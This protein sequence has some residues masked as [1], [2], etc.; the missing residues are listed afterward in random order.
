VWPR[1][2][3]QAVARLAGTGVRVATVVNFPA[4]GTD[5]AATVT[6][7]TQALADGADEIDLVLPY[8]AF[9]DGDVA[10]APRRW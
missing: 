3:A 8:H 4:G 9:L 5:V 1:F 7:T 2:V 10:C 6:E